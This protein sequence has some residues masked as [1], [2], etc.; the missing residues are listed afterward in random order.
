[1]PQLDRLDFVAI[2]FETANQEHASVCQVGLVK[3]VD[4]KIVEEEDWL[5]I[6][7][8]GLD[9]FSPVN[10]AI[11]GIRPNR[12]RRHGIA[13]QESLRRIRAIA[14][15]LPF[16]AHNSRFDRSVYEAATIASGLAVPVTRWEDTVALSR[17][18]LV[19]DNYKLPTVAA[20]VGAGAFSHHDAAADA[21]ACAQIALA[22]AQRKRL[23]SVDA[24]WP[25]KGR[26]FSPEW[27]DR[28]NTAKVSELPQPDPQA[29]ADHPMRGHSVVLTGQLD[30]MTRWEVFEAIAAGGGKPQKNVTLKTTLLVIA[31]QETLPPGNRMLTTQKARKA[32]EYQERGTGIRIIGAREF[33]SML[34]GSVRTTPSGQQPE[35]SVRPRA[36]SVDNEPGVGATSEPRVTPNR[37]TAPKPRVTPDPAAKTPPEA[38]SKA[39]LQPESPAATARLAPARQPVGATPSKVSPTFSDNRM[40]QGPQR[41]GM[42]GKVFGWVLLVGASLVG[43]LWT[44]AVGVGLIVS[45]PG[46]ATTLGVVILT[47]LILAAM[48]ALGYWGVW[49][50]WLR[51]R[52]SDRTPRN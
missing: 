3:V 37:E 1:M 22:I 43:L 52:R 44:L 27:A 38:D 28:S 31:D 36:A 33:R 21:R 34:A 10:V 42:A 7:P 32:L 11:H 29:P 45:F 40:T 16:I 49:L 8:T 23:A 19:L 2:D 39:P 24:L 9:A 30:G 13:W 48:A 12:V 14:G 25:P 15:E 17:R 35:K 50:I 41:R 46:V 5:V 26:R 4:G 6:P 18:H 47:L 20:A 51:Y